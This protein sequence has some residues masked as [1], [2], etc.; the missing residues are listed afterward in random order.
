MSQDVLCIY[1]SRTGKT[2]AVMEQLA[3]ALEA[4]AVPL[5]DAVERQGPLGWLRC[6]LDAVSRSVPA[7]APVECRRALEEY[8]LVIVGT[9]VWAG[10][11]SSVVRSFLKTYGHRL[12]RVAYVLTRDAQGRHEEIYTQM[13]LYTARPHRCAVSLRVGDVSQD[14]W[15]ADFLRQVREVLAQEPPEADGG[16]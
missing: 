16:P 12:E 7:V 2:K 15:Q 11:C 8:R 6:A 1:Y 10:R 13:D 4:E 14:F 3:Q 5:G 9:P